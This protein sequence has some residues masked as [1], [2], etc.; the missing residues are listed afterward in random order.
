MPRSNLLPNR[1]RSD[2]LRM[3]A[4]IELTGGR[5]RRAR[6]M[7]VA[8]IRLRRHADELYVEYARAVSADPD[9]NPRMAVKALRHAVRID[10]LEAGSWAALGAAAI[11][12]GEIKLAR[13]AFRRAAR[14]HPESV[15]TLSEIVS[16]AAGPRPG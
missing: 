8:A 5:F 7:L 12:A 4:D 9:G 15:A 1:L 3:L 6:R 16:S 10:P 11:R 13:T 2:V 14:L